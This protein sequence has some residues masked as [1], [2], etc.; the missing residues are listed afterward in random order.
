MN[1]STILV[2]FLH[3]TL[4]TMLVAQEVVRDTIQYAGLERSYLLYV[5][6]DYQPEEN[7]PLV[8]V[9]HGGGNGNGEEI[10]QRLRFHEVADTAGYLCFIPNGSDN[11]WADGRGATTP[12]LEG[13]N[14]VQFLQ[15]VLDTLVQDYPF[16]HNNVFVTGASN[17]GMMTQRLACE[18]TSRFRAYASIIASMPEPVAQNCS[19]D[20]PVPM[21]LMNG[22]E[23][24]LVPYE[25]GPLSPL[26]D[27]GSVT[28]T[29]STISF[30]RN[31]NACN[32][33]VELVDVADTDLTDG[34]TV[35]YSRWGSCADSTDVVLYRVEGGGHTVPGM[36]A[37]Q[38]PRPL[39]GYVNYDIEAATE[40]W[41]F[42]KSHL[43]SGTTSS[44]DRIDPVEQI[45]VFPNPS[46]GELHIQ[47]LERYTDFHIQLSDQQGRVLVHAQNKHAIDTSQ[48]PKGMYY[49]QIRTEGK[50]L[51]RVV[52][53]R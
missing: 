47:G 41:A 21:L 29:D 15:D 18:A 35:Q 39:V 53:M 20:I 32:S 16:D 5:P 25:G 43:A 48:L 3:L 52:A 42:F 4:A 17:G 38:N 33:S 46:S 14:D 51:N 1:R 50:V 19:P 24:T 10:L 36:V 34:S 26:T 23:D 30:W 31:I 44:R 6:A 27:G 8:M 45:R 22:T 49:L 12:D 37:A 11:Q 9:L 7:W 13:V 2:A 40:I 28:G